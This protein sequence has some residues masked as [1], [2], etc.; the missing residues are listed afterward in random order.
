MSSQPLGGAGKP[1]AYPSYVVNIPCKVGSDIDSD[2]DTSSG[3]E[4]DGAYPTS[5]LDNPHSA[6]RLFPKPSKASGPV[7]RG[8]IV[9]SVPALTK[10]VKIQKTQK[11]SPPLLNLFEQEVTMSS[12]ELGK[13]LGVVIGFNKMRSLSNSKNG[14]LA[15][16][17][18]TCFRD[19]VAT[20]VLGFMWDGVWQE[21]VE[22]K[23]KKGKGKGKHIWVDTTYAKVHDFYRQL[24][25]RSKYGAQA[26]LAEVEGRGRGHMV[27]YREIRDVIKNAP[28]TKA[29]VGELRTLN[30]RDV[31]VF[32]MDD[33]MKSLRQNAKAPST[34]MVLDEHYKEKPFEI[35]STG[36]VIKCPGQPFLELGVQA[37]LCV[38]HAT[39]LVYFPEP[40]AAI[41]VVK[42]ADT[43]TGNFADAKDPHYKSPQEMTRLIGTV[44]KTRGLDPR[45]VMV[46]DA[47]GA[48]ET[49]LPERMEREFAGALSRQHGF[50]LWGQI[51]FKTMKGINQSHYDCNSW[52]KNLMPF[53]K[54]RKDIVI[55]GNQ[56]QDAGVLSRALVSL[57]TRVF[58]TLI[59]L[60]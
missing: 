60:N 52:A 36:Y 55:D 48:I 8:S 16:R 26:F 50:I 38:R 3:E 58:S 9:T 42:G 24:K 54:C 13:R 32:F 23:G 25:K 20:S 51:H 21:L 45:E 14:S 44:L 19:K 10:R 15:K 27:P 49:A 5:A 34:F 35:G 46:F 31:Y 4:M 30:E 12:T 2:G 57:L 47:R 56:I 43:V 18:D 17:V 37:D 1:S 7:K 11:V 6:Y 29:L 39:Q 41:K 28:A 22:T 33:D 40:C 59:L 53:L